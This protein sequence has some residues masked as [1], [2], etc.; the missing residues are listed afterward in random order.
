MHTYERRRYLVS[1]L[2]YRL[3]AFNLLYALVIFL[4][5]AA[6][7]FVPPMLRLDD[8]DA[9]EFFLLLHSRIW[10]GLLLVLLLLSLHSV[11]VSHRI[12]GPLYR[13]RKVFQSLARV[14]FP[15]GRGFAGR[16]TCRKKPR[17]SMR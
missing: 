12:A 4:S 5:L 10:P 2:Q 3:L 14:T 16:I 11:M 6:A 1:R 9:A 17:P 7:I 13:F 15:S 8:Y